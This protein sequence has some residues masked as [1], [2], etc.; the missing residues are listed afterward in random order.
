MGGETQQRWSPRD[1]LPPRPCWTVPRRPE[2]MDADVVE[3]NGGPGRCVHHGR[4]RMPGGAGVPRGISG[5][6][7]GK[8]SEGWNPR[9]VSGVKESCKGTGRNK[10]SRS[11]KSSKAQHS[12]V[13]Q[14]RCRSLPRTSYAEGAQKPQERRPREGRPGSGHTLERSEVHGR[15]R[16]RTAHPGPSGAHGNALEITCP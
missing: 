5:R 16:V 11:R 7:G 14:A 2:R 13:R 10:A 4:R 15:I 6:S 8:T 9:S 1:D 3:M 12:R